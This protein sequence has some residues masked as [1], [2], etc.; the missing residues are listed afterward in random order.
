MNAL[1]TALKHLNTSACP[2]FAPAPRLR[3]TLCATLLCLAASACGSVPTKNDQ[4]QTDEQQRRIDRI[5]ER[6]NRHY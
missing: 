3:A 4:E 6:A 5:M 2:V 1:I